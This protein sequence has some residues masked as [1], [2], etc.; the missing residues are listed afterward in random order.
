[1]TA[2]D[3]A[4]GTARRKSENWHAI[5]E[6]AIMAAMLGINPCEDE[7]WNRQNL[8]YVRR[9]TAHQQSGYHDQIAGDVRGE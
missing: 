1:M 4:P 3:G 5:A 2:V 9:P 8:I 6:T 7:D